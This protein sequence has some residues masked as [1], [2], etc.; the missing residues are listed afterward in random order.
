MNIVI[1]TNILIS[2]LIKDSITRKII[3]QSGFRFYYPEISLMELKK[4]RDYIIKKSKISEKDFDVLLNKI[5]EYI[6]TIPEDIIKL[7]L[8][9]NN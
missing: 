1:D 5:L 9:I 3:I 8:A 4:Y 6:I 2:A 7:K